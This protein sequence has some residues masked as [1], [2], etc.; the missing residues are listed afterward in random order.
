MPRP[1]YS[2]HPLYFAAP[3][4]LSLSPCLASVPPCFHASLTSPRRASVPPSPRRPSI[5]C[6]WFRCL[7]PT[8]VASISDRAQD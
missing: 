8:P 5:P 1:L 4:S 6:A 7:A 2:T 3:L